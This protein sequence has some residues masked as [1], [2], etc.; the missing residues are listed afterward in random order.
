MQ[1][2]GIVARPILS[3]GVHVPYQGGTSLLTVAYMDE[4]HV[5]HRQMR[6]LVTRII[7]NDIPEKPTLVSVSFGHIRAGKT[8]LSK[9]FTAWV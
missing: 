7:R 5:A 8:S 3:P 4:R 9:P 6:R 2:K 1:E